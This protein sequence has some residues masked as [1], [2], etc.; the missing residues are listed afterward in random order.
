MT[1]HDI[2]TFRT[3]LSLR[4]F[5]SKSSTSP[6]H[7]RKLALSELRSPFLSQLHYSNPISC[8]TQI[9][10]TSQLDK[11]RVKN[12]TTVSPILLIKK[13]KVIAFYVMSQNYLPFCT[14]LLVYIYAL[15]KND[16]PIPLFFFFFF[17]SSYFNFKT[18]PASASIYQ[19]SNCYL[20]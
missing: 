6:N 10:S 2:S 12:G 15:T 11:K 13:R 19:S 1:L 3:N 20:N 9:Q 17:F 5:P 16:S 4:Y 7:Y 14:R 18:S 8:A